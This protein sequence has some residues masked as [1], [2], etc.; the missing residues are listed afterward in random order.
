[1]KRIT[2]LLT[3][4][5]IAGL[6]PPLAAEP[7]L[8]FLLG[9]KE[10]KTLETV[11]EFFESELKPRGY[12]ATFI[13]APPE[14]GKRD[15][16]SGLAEALQKA[17]LCVISVRRR[18]PAIKDMQALKNFVAEGNP[19]V[20]I[21]TSSH[22]FHLRG[23]K[24]PEGRELW[25]AFDREILGGNYH[26]HYGNELVEISVDP[27]AKEHPIL[28]GVEKLPP[29]DKLYEPRPLTKSTTPLLYGNLPGKNPEPVAWTNRAGEKRAKV[30]Y[31]SLGQKS[32]FEDAAFR[33]FL[34]N[35]I[36]WALDET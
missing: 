11:P 33:K 35:A 8:V 5:S 32:D 23:K 36:E 4:L 9:E 7:H 31:T 3:A 15:D 13:T 21:R 2:L 20:A 27:E 22:A 19:I 14:E 12:T 17:D 16:F 30:F 24:A 18:A 34:A 29:S 25:E 26:G 1:M 6:L 10:Y 28:K